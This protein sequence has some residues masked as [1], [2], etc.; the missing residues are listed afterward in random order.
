MDSALLMK[1]AI[2]MSSAP[3][4]AIAAT[5]MWSV[6]NSFSGVR[7]S[8]LQIITLTTIPSMYFLSHVCYLSQKDACA[9]AVLADGS[10]S[11]R[12][13]T[14]ASV[15]ADRASKF[16][17]QNCGWK[18]ESVCDGLVLAKIGS[19]ARQSPHRQQLVF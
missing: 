4:T 3:G 2:A 12:C 1:P 9:S 10:C 15:S 17:V 7:T 13:G 18:L 16:A 11:G 14:W 8:L 19:S 5:I 6:F